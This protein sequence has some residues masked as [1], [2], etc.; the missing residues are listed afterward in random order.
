M[1]KARFFQSDAYVSID[2]AEQ[3]VEVYRL[4]PQNGGRPS[5]Q[6]RR[7]DVVRDEPLHRELADF[8]DAVRHQRRPGVT[9]EDG[10]E[11]LALATR[12]AELM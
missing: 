12:I 6:G 8:V 11:A 9:G 1:R 2:Y 3:E 7:L 5:I 10:R 4:V